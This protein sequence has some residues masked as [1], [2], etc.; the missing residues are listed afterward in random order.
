MEHKCSICL[1]AVKNV[2]ELYV[3]LASVHYGIEPEKMYIRSSDEESLSHSSIQYPTRSKAALCSLCRMVFNGTRNLFNHFRIKHFARNYDPTGEP[4]KKRRKTEK[5]VHQ[6]TDLSRNMDQVGYGNETNSKHDKRKQPT[7]AVQMRINSDFSLRV[8]T[9]EEHNE[10]NAP[11][12]PNVLDNE[13]FRLIEVSRR[14]NSQYNANDVTYRVAVGQHL[15]NRRIVD[16]QEQLY[17]M[18]EDLLSS[19]RQELQDDDLICIYMNHSEL[20]V[21]IVIS[22]HPI[23]EMQVEDI[24]VEVEKVLQSE[25]ELKLDENFEIHVGTLKIP[26]G[27]RGRNDILNKRENI[28]FKRIIVTIENS[29]DNLCFDRSLVVCMAKLSSQTSAKKWKIIIDKRS[30]LQKQ[31]ALQL[32][33]RVGLPKDTPITLQQIRIY[34]QA[35]DVQIIVISIEKTILYHGSESRENKVFLYKDGDHFHSI[36][37]IRGFYGKNNYCKTCLVAY[38]N[39]NHNCST[40]CVVCQSQKCPQ[41][42]NGSVKCTDCNMSCRSQECYERHKKKKK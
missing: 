17:E 28:C 36:V 25:E 40:T 19:M 37:N 5:G 29:D 30:P 14:H 22:A 11:T 20:H 24:M 18:F 1:L 35:L 8:P 6:I 23:Q 26:R 7:P 3:H 2:R 34:E 9:V 38:N 33:L 41:V 10:D 21:P 39:G 4:A 42:P 16:V 13:T 32:R 31:E 27:G 12:P 15:I